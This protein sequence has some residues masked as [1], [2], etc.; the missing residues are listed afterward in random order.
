MQ[1]CLP[2]AFSVL[3]VC[4]CGTPGHQ[5]SGSP[6]QAAPAKTR[7]PGSPLTFEP[8]PDWVVESPTSSMR[9][10]Q[11]RLPRAEGDAEDAECVVYYFGAQG[12]GGLEA[13]IE[14]WCSQFE[15]VDGSDSMDVL[16]HGERNLEEILEA[17]DHPTQHCGK[18]PW[19]RREVAQARVPGE[20]H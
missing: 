19:L 8:A 13:N 12:G 6:E 11:Y 20:R 17:R 10:A 3:L 1:F 2:L 18:V 15:Q 7:S 5:A 14:R 16:A 9:K 4:G